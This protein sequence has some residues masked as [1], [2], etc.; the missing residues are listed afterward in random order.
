MCFH[1][2]YKTNFQIGTLGPK[3]NKHGFK[4]AKTVC[5]LSVY[6][7]VLGQINRE[8]SCSSLQADTCSAL[9][10]IFPEQLGLFQRWL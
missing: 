7:D 4:Q 9:S 10:N 5:K 1:T 3:R 8:H 2:F 6:F